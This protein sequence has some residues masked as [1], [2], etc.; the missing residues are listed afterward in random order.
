M[1]AWINQ[2]CR[3]VRNLDGVPHHFFIGAE[4]PLERLRSPYG[5]LGDQLWVRETWSSDF[6]NHYPFDQFWYSA[7][8]DLRHDIEVRNGVR[9]IYS[10]DHMEHV[11]FRWR[12]SIHMPRSAC[13]ILLEV[14]S[15]RVERLQD[16]SETDSI[17]EGVRQHDERRRWVN[18]CALS[19]GKRH[20]SASAYDMYHQL[21]DDLN[22]KRGHGW[23]V[24]PWVWVVEFKRVTP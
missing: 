5:Q 20:F 1:N 9:G 3:E 11:P 23:D 14:V 4:Q 21:W 12:P 7:D 8:D 10:P 13:R 19:D 24:N 6:A 17:A 15:V 16:I 2:A 22:A 18:E